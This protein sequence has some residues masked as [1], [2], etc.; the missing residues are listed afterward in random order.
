MALR[1]ATPIKHSPIGVTDV[2]DGTQAAQGSMA[3]LTNLIHDPTSRGVFY[4]RPA[5]IKLTPFTGFSSPG[6]VSAFEV[7]G[8]K[9]YGLIATSRNAGHDE[10]FVYDLAG[11]NFVTVG[12]VTSANT[13]TSPSPTGTWTPPT[14]ALVG[15]K[16]IVTHPGFSGVGGNMFGW[17][18]LTNPA[19]PTWNAGN[20]TTNALPA[21]PVA[22][23]N[24]YNR[25]YFAVNNAVYASDVLAATVITNASQILTI[26]DNVNVTALGGLGVYSAIQGGIVQALIVFKSVESMWQ[27]TGD[28]ATTNL[29]VNAMNV[30]TGT[31]APNTIQASPKGLFFISPEGLRVVD[32]QGNVSDPIGSYGTGVAVPFI[33]S[34]VP[35]RMCAAFNGNILRVTTQN[36]AV[37]GQPQQEWWY[38]VTLDS[39]TGPHTSAASLIEAYLGT[40]VVCPVAFT[41][42]IWQS[43]PVQ[44]GTS[45]FLE[46]GVQL[47]WNWQTS[48]LPDNEVM[49]V[50]AMVE[51]TIRIGFDASI[52]TYNIY[53]IDQDGQVLD[54]VSQIATGTSTFWGAFNWGAAVWRGTATAL[55][56][57]QIAWHVPI[58]FN[59]LA[60]RIT[61]NS[62]ASLKLGNLFMRYQVQRYL[63]SNT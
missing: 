49:S 12:G 30:A 7:I 43:D 26:G 1:N 46:N 24:F 28:F 39:W 57:Q 6:F 52:G 62:A 18:D 33:N 14:F 27:I 40:F 58:V 50:N 37:A 36:G 60:I 56:P 17:F 9:A 51:A 25:C 29:V 41:A 3:A 2:L 34:A 22:A 59:T 19:S 53:A 55:Q 21:P 13:P 47:T 35:S 8:T 4:C 20:T 61:G 23:F 38:N 54:T 16:L 44:N 10:P 42:S 5:M 32:Q 11:G 48:F 63:L 45:S 15:T 31:L